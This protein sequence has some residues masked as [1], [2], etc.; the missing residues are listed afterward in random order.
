MTGGA[1]FIGGNFVLG[2]VAQGIRVVNLD[3]LTYAGNMDTLSSLEGDPNHVFVQGDIGDAGLV[4]RLLS[5]HRPDAV[6]NFA[7][8]SH[9]DRSIDGPA[10]FVQTNVV[11]TLS[12]LEKTRD[13]WKAL[14]PAARDAFRFLHVSTDEVYGSLGETGKFSETTPYAPNSPYSA[15]KAASDHLVRA[16]HHTY[17]LPVLTTNCSNNYGPYHFP[18]KLIPLVIARALA[19]E[20][21]P[22]YGDGRQVRDW[23]FVRDHCEAIR[24]VLERGRIGETYNVGGNSEKQNIEV[25]KTICRLLDERRPREDGKP[26]E[27]QIAFVADRPGHDR[28]YA[29]DASKLKNELGWEPRYT[30]ERGIAETVDWY[31]DNQPWVQRVLDGSYRLERIGQG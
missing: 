4:E 1:G 9:V 31:L 13:Y 15:S 26:R 20:P 2:A 29:I 10:A 5:E 8:E 25:V 14:E 23:L 6:I 28:R 7:A 3:A 22:V 16:F 27:S 18:E 12:L 21:L 17:G 19:G 11:G 24:T 30:F